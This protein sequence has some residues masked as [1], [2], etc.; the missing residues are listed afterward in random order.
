MTPHIEGHNSW[1]K[2]IL[3]NPILAKVIVRLCC[4][5]QTLI[6]AFNKY[7]IYIDAL[8][9]M[10]HRLGNT[11]YSGANMLHP[12]GLVLEYDTH[13]KIVQSWHSN[14]PM[15]SK[16]CEGFLY[17]GQMYLGSPYN[18]LALKVPYN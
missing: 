4:F 5:V 2:T 18:T 7:V 8:A 14:D 12:Y 1:I 15:V 13:G 16:I 11:E 17:H 9:I 10:V 6:E 3:C